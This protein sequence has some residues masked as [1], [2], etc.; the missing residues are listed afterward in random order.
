MQA[1]SKD[2]GSFLLEFRDGGAQ[3]HFQSTREL[4]KSEVE[5]AFLQ[6]LAGDG[7]WRVAGP[8]RKLEFPVKP[9]WRFW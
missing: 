5:R 3:S 8:W 9:W 6:Y 2:D 1:A 4:T 7:S